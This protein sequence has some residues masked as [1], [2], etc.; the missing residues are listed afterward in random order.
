MKLQLTRDGEIIDVKNVTVILGDT[1]FKIQANNQG[2]LEIMKI[3]FD[4]GNIQ[5]LPNY[6][7]QVTLK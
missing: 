6:S 5:V 7:N 2:G 3:N 1:E 4:D